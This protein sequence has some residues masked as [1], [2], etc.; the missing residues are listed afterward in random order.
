MTTHFQRLEP[1]GDR[2]PIPAAILPTARA[3]IVLWLDLLAAW[4]KSVD[5]VSARTPEELTDLMLTD[6][7]VLGARLPFGARV[8]DVGTGAGA[9]GLA[10]AL[11]R[12]DLRVTLVEPMNKRVSFLR[13]TLGTTGRTD[14]NLERA[15]GEE[16]AQRGEKWDV[17]VARA[18]LPPA[19]W[20]ELGTR[21]V[22]DPGGSVWVLLARGEPPA[23]RGWATVEEVRYTQP[24]TQ[25]P[26]RAVRYTRAFA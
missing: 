24:Q 25:A 3:H 4:N 5:L 9:P 13:T 7:M 10:L 8:V 2:W 1:L 16:L 20:L 21:V 6:A 18:T 14:V 26:R 11:L 22:S 23:R 17:A 12:P 15:R 19:A